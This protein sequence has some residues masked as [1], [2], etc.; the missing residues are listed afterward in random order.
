MFPLESIVKK[1]VAP[2][3]EGRVIVVSA[4]MAAGGANVR[5]L[6]L[7]VKF[8]RMIDALSMLAGVLAA[9]CHTNV[10]LAET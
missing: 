4:P 3:K 8:L 5:P 7:A 6:E 10:L 9:D 1:L 2:G